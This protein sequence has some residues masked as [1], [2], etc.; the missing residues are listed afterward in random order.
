MLDKRTVQ[1]TPAWH[2]L[3]RQSIGA[4]DAAS[5]L[6]ISPYKTQ[7][8]LYC[9]K[10]GLTEDAEPSYAM[11]RGTRLEPEAISLYE[12]VTGEQFFPAVIFH[13]KYNFIIASL[14]GMNLEGTA[15]VEVKCP[16]KATHDMATRGEVPHHYMAQLQHQMM[17]SKLP[18]IDYYSYDGS[19]GVRLTVERDEEYIKTLLEAEL[20]FWA[21]VKSRTPPPLSDKDCQLKDGDP[22]WFKYADALRTVEKKI[23]ALEEEKTEIKKHIMEL[24]EGRSC[25]GCG[26]TVY[27]TLRQGT[28]D[29]S[30]ID[31]L[32]DIDIDRYRKPAKLVWAIRI[33]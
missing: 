1:R 29:Y 30:S 13:P 18:R 10:L 2:E 21:L 22:E 8:Q 5:C 9:E 24:S 26:V 27:S 19:V 12:E 25:K 15:A 32:K 3:R 20:A 16:G 33:S 23:K 11:Q 17:C 4:S 14:D 28:I 31:A 6:G 7:Y